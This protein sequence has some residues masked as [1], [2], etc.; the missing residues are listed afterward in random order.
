[1]KVTTPSFSAA[2]PSLLSG[3][4]ACSAR[5]S[6]ASSSRPH[7]L[8]VLSNTNFDRH[9]AMPSA[10]QFCCAKSRACAVIGMLAHGSAADIIKIDNDNLRKVRADL[11]SPSSASIATLFHALPS[12]IHTARLCAGPGMSV[13][14]LHMWLRASSSGFCACASTHSVD[15]GPAVVCASER[16]GAAGPFAS[17][18][19]FQRGFVTLWSLRSH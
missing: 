2:L 3:A 4:P 8:G 17:D 18:C 11:L 16:P 12:H 10:V 15:V 5:P 6:E 9:G 7:S 19:H 14:M 1:M 13:Y